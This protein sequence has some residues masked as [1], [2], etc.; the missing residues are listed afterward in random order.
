M[1]ASCS[2]CRFFGCMSKM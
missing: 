2:C 1:K